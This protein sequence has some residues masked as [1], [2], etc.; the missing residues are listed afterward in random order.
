MPV[1]GR[2]SPARALIRDAGKITAIGADR[3]EHRLLRVPYPGGRNRRYLG[4]I[5]SG[6][7]AIGD[8]LP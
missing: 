7:R 3:R 4:A 2:S 8:L 6:F 1:S 5:E